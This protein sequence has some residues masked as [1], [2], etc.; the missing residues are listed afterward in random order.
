M[1][2]TWS[3]VRG[4]WYDFGLSDLQI[5]MRI[6][7][8][9]WQYIYIHIVLHINWIVRYGQDMKVYLYFLRFYI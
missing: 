2:C 5:T 7:R 1:V 6:D 9:K 3:I 4:K 8:H